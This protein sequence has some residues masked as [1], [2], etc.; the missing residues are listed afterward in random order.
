[1]LFFF[2]KSILRLS[3]WVSIPQNQPYSFWVRASTLA[4]DGPE[5]EVVSETPQ[6]PAPAALASFSRVV[7]AAVRE[8][9]TMECV[10]VGQ[11]GPNR[12]WT[13]E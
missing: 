5:S 3:C 7:I 11:P 1:M 10:A 12:R 4:G 8:E 13:R 2:F 9:A 6:S